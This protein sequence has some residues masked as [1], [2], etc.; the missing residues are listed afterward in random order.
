MGTRLFH[1]CRYLA[2]VI[3]AMII[4]SPFFGEAFAGLLIGMTLIIIGIQMISAGIGGRETLLIA[5][6]LKNNNNVDEKINL[7]KMIAY[8]F[9]NSR[10]LKI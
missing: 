8:T 10:L 9:W 6:R 4:A 5:P 1:R 7:A 3:S 2:V